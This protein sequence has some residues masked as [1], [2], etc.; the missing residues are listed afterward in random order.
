M[1]PRTDP[2]R[3]IERAAPASTG[4]TYV[5]ARDGSEDHAVR[6]PF[7]ASRGSIVTHMLLKRNVWVDPVTG[8][9]YTRVA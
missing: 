1:I 5:V 4:V 2:N 8:D 3:H 7:T 6:G 9:K